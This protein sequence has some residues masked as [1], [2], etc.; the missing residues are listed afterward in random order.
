MRTKWW[1]IICFL[2][3]KRCPKWEECQLKNF[4]WDPTRSWWLIQ[5]PRSPVPS[6]RINFKLNQSLNINLILKETLR[7]DLILAIWNNP[8]PKKISVT[9]PSLLKNRLKVLKKFFSRKRKNSNKMKKISNLYIHN[10]FMREIK[11]FSQI[12]NL[13]IKR[14]LIPICFLI[15]P[16]CSSNNPRKICRIKKIFLWARSKSKKKLPVIEIITLKK[17]KMMKTKCQSKTNNRKYSQISLFSN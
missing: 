3:K 13:Q 1:S 17:R 8:K 11:T 10:L 15:T 16:K 5:F 2:G 4:P 12:L 7:E 6:I 14:I 9:R